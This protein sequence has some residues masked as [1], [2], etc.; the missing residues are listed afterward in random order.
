MYGGI[1]RWVFS[2]C[3]RGSFGILEGVYDLI[4][5]IYGLNNYV[6]VYK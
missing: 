3:I 5:Y 4:L 2:D 1:Q 6:C